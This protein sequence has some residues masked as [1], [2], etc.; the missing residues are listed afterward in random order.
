MLHLDT[1]P[2]LIELSANNH[3]VWFEANKQRY[4]IIKDALIGFVAQ[5][6]SQMLAFD[7][8]I[9]SAE[10]KKSVFRIYRDTRFSN[11]KLPYKNNMGAYLSPKLNVKE[12]WSPGY[13]L[14]IDAENCFVAGGVYEPQSPELLKIRNYISLHAA[15]LREIISHPDFVRLFGGLEGEKL[16]T[17]PKGFPKDHPDIDLLQYKSI[18]ASRK[19]PVEVLFSD[20]G[21]AAVTEIS[22]AIFPLN[23][24]LRAALGV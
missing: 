16:K 4:T 24:F 5:W 1:L 23:Q 9:A 6:Q 7:E 10:P 17:A 8:A 15:E 3:K 19:I 11:N 20:E 21:L 22:R 12:A 13:Y 14:H 2:F 18:I